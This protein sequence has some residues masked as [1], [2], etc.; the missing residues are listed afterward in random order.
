MTLKQSP[1]SDGRFAW[2]EHAQS[3]QAT[4]LDLL[5]I[6]RALGCS[7]EIERYSVPDLREALRARIFLLRTGFLNKTALPKKD[8]DQ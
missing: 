8:Q 6:A 5:D 2:S 7:S 3:R 4:K 1:P